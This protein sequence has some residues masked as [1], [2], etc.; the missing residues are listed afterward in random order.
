MKKRIIS[1]L[2]VLVFCLTATIPALAANVFMFTTK[3]VNIYEG[4][5]LQMELT[6][7]GSYA[8]AGEITYSTGKKTVATI[9]KDGLLKAVSK[10]RTEVTA[11]LTRNGKQ[12]GRAVATVNVLRAVKK[13]TLSTAKLSV[14]EPD[15]PAIADL[16]KEAT[17]NRV[18]VIP[19]GAQ[20]TL[21]AT[22]T[23]E[24]AS[25]TKVNFSTTDAGVAK[26]TGTTLKAIQAGECDLVV[27]SAQRSKVKETFRVL[28]IQPVES[29]KI[30][31]G[32]KVEVG[33]TR[34]LKASC[35]PKKAAIKGVTW[36]SQTPKIAKVNSKG[37]VTGL[38]RGTAVITATARDGSHVTA[39]Y[40]MNVTQPVTSVSMNQ[41]KI[42]VIA[43][44][45][46]MARATVL[47]ADASDKSLIWYT[48]DEKI[49]TVRGNGQ[50]V[51]V[52]AGTCTLYCKS[53]S[54]PE[55]KASAKV[56]VS[57][58]V[59]K[60]INS[61]KE[62]ELTIRVGEKVQTRWK[63]KPK[64]ATVTA[65]TFSSRATK[66]ATVN[67]KGVVTGQNR[68]VVTINATA[69]DGSKKTG[70][71][72]VT[73][74]QPVT[75]VSIPKARYY[76]QRGSGSTLRAIIQPRNANNQKVYWSSMDEKIATIKSNGTSTGFVRGVSNGKTRIHAYTEDGGFIASTEVRIGNYNNAVRIEELY[77]DGGNNIRI[78]LRNNTS[79]MTLKSVGFVIECFDLDGERFICNTDGKSKKFEGYYPYLLSPNERTIHG[80]FTFRNY[81]IDRPLGAVVLTLTSWYDEDGYSYV[82]PGG[83]RPTMT[84]YKYNNIRPNYGEGNG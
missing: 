68:G 2:A 64:D 39:T 47:P 70:S 43:G 54:N 21:S 48:S 71:V 77:V 28:V 29:I 55:L 42:S 40:T 8:S 57:Q 81:V 52:K 59:T 75:G 1:C 20:A 74:I 13:V 32:K 18:I 27:A 56:V 73:V 76:V 14:Y 65:L 34:Q 22:C 30:S 5:T 69:T 38:K 19:A 51:G 58:L 61:N 78:T 80:C 3:I 4:D 26:V 79:K 33:A 24:D 23:P 35:S 11:T 53:V 84:W 50:V 36:K 72:K 17:E 12:A 44:R 25:N 67:S 31:G 63:I 41:K 46:A 62:S 6:R 60:V 49:A 7:E 37:V 66:V 9:S 45:T 82:I 10:G 16:L 83:S 15:D